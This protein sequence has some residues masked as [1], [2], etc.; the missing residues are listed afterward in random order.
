ML[1]VVD[2]A[3]GDQQPGAEDPAGQN[4]HGDAAAARD[5]V[6]RDHAEHVAAGDVFIAGLP[7]RRVF[8]IP[9]RDAVVAAH[10]VFTFRR[11]GLVVV[12]DGDLVWL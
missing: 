9:V 11:R 6:A 10:T 1:A 3:D 5:V 2:G 4:A 12:R 8:R 7:G